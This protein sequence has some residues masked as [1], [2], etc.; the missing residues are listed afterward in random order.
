MNQV[1][2]EIAG[3][4]A[5]LQFA[6]TSSIR[7][8]HAFGFVVRWHSHTIMTEMPVHRESLPWA[9]ARRLERNEWRLPLLAAR[10]DHA[11]VVDIHSSHERGDFAI[12]VF[13]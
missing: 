11:H 7:R 1:A 2:G 12:L 6:E 13:R 4:A 8:T 9:S 10:V 3:N 5:R